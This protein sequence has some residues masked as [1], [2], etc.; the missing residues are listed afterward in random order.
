MD[1][2]WTRHV[3]CP[4]VAEYVDMVDHKTGGLFNLV[5]GLM[6]AE[7]C[8]DHHLPLNSMMTLLGRYFQIRDDYNNLVSADYI[9]AK[10]FCEDLDEGKFSLPLIHALRISQKQKQRLRAILQERRHNGSGMCVEMKS[11][12]L[13]ML[14][15]AGSLEYVRQV[16]KELED[17]IDAEIRRV[18]EIVG[19]EN[20]V[21]RL[22]VE[23]LKVD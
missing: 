8:C 22:L 19:E 3:A 20:F 23:R 21:F 2:Y 4:T 17:A 14:R 7:G 16:L 1:L 11:L 15:D 9:A 6:Q 18:E 10:G 5:G 13:E 12:V